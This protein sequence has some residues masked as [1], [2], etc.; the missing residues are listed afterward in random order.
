MRFQITMNMPSRSGNSVHQ[1]IGEHPAK[2][3]EE[4]VNILSQ[5]DFIIVDEIYKDN[6]A[7]RGMG[8]FYSV[9]KLAI[10]PLFIGKIKVFSQ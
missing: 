7:A 10:N 6:D 8:N 4:L 1:V 5:S 2:T 3:L 9:G